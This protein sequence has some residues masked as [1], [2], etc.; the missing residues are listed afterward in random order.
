MSMLVNFVTLAQLSVCQ[1]QQQVVP[2]DD[3]DVDEENGGQDPGGEYDGEYDATGMMSMRRMAVRTLTASTM[4]SM[5]RR[6]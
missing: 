2:Y 5:T 3:Y 4:A 1:K 6:V